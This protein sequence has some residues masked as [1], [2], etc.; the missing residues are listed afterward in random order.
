MQLYYHPN[1]QNCIKVLAVAHQL[2]IPLELRVVD[3][4]TGAQRSP[5]YLKLNP[6]GKV[7][8]LVDGD[9]VLWE[10][11]AIIQY[12]ATRKPGTG[13]WPADERL[14]ADITRWQCWQLAHWAPATDSLTWENLFKPMLKL[15]APNA[16]VVNRA[17]EQ[18]KFF[19]EVLDRHLANRDYIVGETWTL[20]DYSLAAHLIYAKPAGIPLAAFPH[21]SRWFGRIEKL[22]AWKKAL[23]PVHE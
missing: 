10:S 19:G 7:P 23:P 1:S 15:G 20:A 2:D 13:L 17:E 9:F 14:R 5:D 22:E 4:A 8:T 11:D 12:L 21:V 6:N 18:L 16:G 3:L